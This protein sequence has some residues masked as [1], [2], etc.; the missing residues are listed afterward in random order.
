MAEKIRNDMPTWSMN[1]FVLSSQDIFLRLESPPQF[2]MGL[3]RVN[4][5]ITATKNL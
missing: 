2:K 5:N 1:E 3:A 4:E